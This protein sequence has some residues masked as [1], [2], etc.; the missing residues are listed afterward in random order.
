M[1][2]SVRGAFGQAFTV[3][4]REELDGQNSSLY[5]DFYQKA[6][7]RFNEKEWIPNSLVL[8]NLHEDFKRSKPLPLNITPI[9][10]EQLKKLSDNRYIMV[11][12]IADWERSGSGR[13]MGRNL[14]QGQ[15]DNDDNSSGNSEN[16]QSEREVYE[17][18]DG[19]DRQSFLHE[20]PSHVL[21]L[22]HLAYKYD[23]LNAMRQQLRN[24]FTADGSSAPDVRSV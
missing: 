15:T 1:D 22:W 2:D 12:V 11:K 18:W 24:E 4:T 14:L 16:Q 13:G 10:A 3:K 7:D 9:T 20:R 17:F 23:I 8:P 19:D 21:Y 6:V 5:K